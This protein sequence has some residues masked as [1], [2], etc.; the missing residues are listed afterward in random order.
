MKRFAEYFIDVIFERLSLHPNPAAHSRFV[1][2]VCT[3][4][5]A[6]MSGMCQIDY[7]HGVEDS[8]CYDHQFPSSNPVYRTFFISPLYYAYFL[9]L[10]TLYMHCICYTK[11]F[12]FFLYNYFNKAFSASLHENILCT[13]S[14]YPV[15]CLIPYIYIYIRTFKKLY[16]PSIPVLRR[17]KFRV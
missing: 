13:C 10:C 4:M 17:N 16:T 8:L 5:Y 14:A 3:C 1:L 6:C 12:A 15:P 9:K 7:T 2:Y 11:L